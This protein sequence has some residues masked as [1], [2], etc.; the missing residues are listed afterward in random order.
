MIRSIMLLVFANCC[1]GTSLWAQ[2]APSDSSASTVLDVKPETEEFKK[3]T[4][5][6]REHLK[7][8]REVMVLYNVGDIAEDSKWKQ[9]WISLAESG[10][11][12]HRRFVH[13][14]LR[15]YL[16]D[17]KSKKTLEQMLFKILKRNVEADRFEG[18]TEV[19]QALVDNNFPDPETLVHLTVSAFAEN[20]LEAAKPA[21]SQLIQKGMASAQ[22]IEKHQN[23]E[24]HEQ[25]WQA[26]LDA[27]KRDAEGEPLPR[28]LIK[29]T[30]GNMEVE[31]FENDAPETV[32][33]FLS[34]VETGYYENVTWH[35]VLQHFMAQTGCQVGDG[36][37]G[38]G[39]M[40]YSEASKPTARK[41]YRGTL[42]LALAQEN[43]G[44][45]PIPNSGGS[46]F[47]ITFLPVAELN[48]SY[49]AFGRVT[50]GI[51]V[52]AN[53]AKVNP[54]EKE[55]KSKPKL[56]PD[57]IIEIEVLNKRDHEYTF[58]KVK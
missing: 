49:T 26:E 28:V 19:A 13:E 41:F 17:P 33:N 42:G 43:E 44:S 3:A 56:P 1:L 50:Q 20:Q 18:M 25:E 31:L 46:Q 2:T 53:I 24:S 47:F 4:D 16:M 12:L 45:D 38:P 55:D 36:T 32:A 9:D 57:E 58:N 39:Y 5:E 10:A 51:E 11:A 23:F 35:R 8:M 6:L 40:I 54:D 34:L 15:E 22:L 7:K 27:R 52:L 14:A 30:K 21:L 48:G 37:G 29:T